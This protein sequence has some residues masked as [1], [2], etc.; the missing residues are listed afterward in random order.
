MLFLFTWLFLFFFRIVC[1]CTSRA[2]KPIWRDRCIDLLRSCSN[3]M[4]EL[5]F[6]RSLLLISLDACS[7]RSTSHFHCT[8]DSRYVLHVC[9]SI[10]LTQY[11]CTLYVC[12]ASKQL[13]PVAEIFASIHTVLHNAIWVVFKLFFLSLFWIFNHFSWHYCQ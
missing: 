12:L 5:D 1:M 3:Q 6:F 11:V 7:Y 13:P 9:A 10:I 2:H 4:H 8:F